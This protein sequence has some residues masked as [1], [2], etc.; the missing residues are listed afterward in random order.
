MRYLLS[1]LFISIVITVQSQ[2]LKEA[3]E[4]VENF[5]FE[6]ALKVLSQ[7]NDTTDIHIL[8]QKGYCYSRLGDYSSAIENY[9]QVLL[10][11]SLNKIA[12][13]PLGQMYSRAN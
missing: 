13:N 1:L 3:N 9:R 6:K 4:L 7:I 8:L 5:Q 12:L 2:N 10:I 11:D